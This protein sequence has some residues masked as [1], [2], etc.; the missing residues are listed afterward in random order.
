MAKKPR[1]PLVRKHQ[2]L[3]EVDLEYLLQ[4][5]NLFTGDQPSFRTSVEARR[6][7]LKRKNFL[8]SLIGKYSERQPN[9]ALRWGSRPWSFYKWEFY[10]EDYSHKYIEFQKAWCREET[11]D[12]EFNFLRSM[13]L[14]LKDEARKF[15][16]Q[17]KRYREYRDSLNLKNQS[18]KPAKRILEFPDKNGKRLNGI[19]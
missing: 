3:S 9:D 10:P 18:Q 19:N 13:D 17:E 7:Y 2:E 8:F 6:A 1:I 12:E 15:L 4:G 11:R 5:Y 16:L 14:L